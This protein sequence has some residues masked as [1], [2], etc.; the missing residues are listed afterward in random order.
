MIEPSQQDI[1][2]EKVSQ[3]QDEIVKEFSGK[4][5]SR[6]QINAYLIFPPREWFGRIKGPHLTAALKGLIEAGKATAS[7][8]MISHG[9][10]LFTFC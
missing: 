1:F 9:K 2:N 3:I 6:D 7:S 5:A 4:V 10:T 8:G